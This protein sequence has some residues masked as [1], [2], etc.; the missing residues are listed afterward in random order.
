MKN[1]NLVLVAFLIGT[2]TLVSFDMPSTIDSE[3]REV[4]VSD[5]CDGWEDGYCEGWKDVKGEYALCPLTPL[6]PLPEL[7][8]DEYKHGYHRA[9]KAGM[10]AARNTN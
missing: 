5:Y 3:N 8:K 1:L 4:I 10:K 6:C 7:F 2:V 9:F